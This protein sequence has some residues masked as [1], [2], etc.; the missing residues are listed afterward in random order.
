[1]EDFGSVGQNNHNKSQTEQR[2][3]RKMCTIL[4]RLNLTVICAILF[5]LTHVLLVG[6]VFNSLSTVKHDL[7][8]GKF[9]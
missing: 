6:T 8:L 4:A 2:R 3:V 7:L 1:M 9:C 5:Q